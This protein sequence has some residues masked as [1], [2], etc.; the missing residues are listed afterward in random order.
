MKLRLAALLLLSLASA[1]RRRPPFRAHESFESQLLK[2]PVIAGLYPFSENKEEF[3]KVFS[4]R[5]DG[6]VSFDKIAAGAPG[7]RVE[8]LYLSPDAGRVAQYSVRPVNMSCPDAYAF[9]KRGID[10]AKA[11]HDTAETELVPVGMATWLTAWDGQKTMEYYHCRDGLLWRL[12]YVDFSA[13]SKTDLI[14]FS[15]ANVEK[16]ALV[17]P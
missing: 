5:R 8:E 3:R 7:E 9:V 4:R 11:E 16:A 17:F 6:E 14:R 10:A 1:C 15:R 12:A 2:V 13:E